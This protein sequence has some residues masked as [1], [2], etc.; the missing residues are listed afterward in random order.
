MLV[1]TFTPAVAVTAALFAFAGP[2]S[3]QHN[4][5]SHG[6]MTMPKKEVKR[7]VV[8]YSAPAYFKAQLEMVYMAYFNTQSALSR[9]LLGEAQKGAAEIQAALE[10]VDM[11]LLEGKAHERWMKHAGVIGK[12]VKTITAAGDIKAAREGFRNLSNALVLTGREFGTSGSQPV[13][14][15]HCPMAFNNKG[16]DWLQNKQDTANPYF[17]KSMFACGQVTETLSPKKM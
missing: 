12:E 3:A 17:G 2:V 13:Y 1:K 9:D 6:S 4:H 11:N 5:G 10:K 15:L 14:V 16:A 7:E 8:K